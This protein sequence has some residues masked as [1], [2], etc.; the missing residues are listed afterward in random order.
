MDTLLVEPHSAF[1]LG[2]LR[3]L[4]DVSVLMLFF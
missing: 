1:D 4:I 3:L 2:V